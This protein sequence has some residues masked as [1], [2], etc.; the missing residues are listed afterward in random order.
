VNAHHRIAVALLADERTYA[1][2]FELAS[3]GTV[4]VDDLGGPHGAGIVGEV[5]PAAVIMER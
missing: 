5:G 1:G 4:A 2:G 3:G